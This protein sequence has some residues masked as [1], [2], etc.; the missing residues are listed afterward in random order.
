MP[1]TSV[2][3]CRALCTF[4]ILSELFALILPVDIKI[5]VKAVLEKAQFN[6]YYCLCGASFEIEKDILK[7]L[8]ASHPFVYKVFTFMRNCDIPLQSFN[9]VELISEREAMLGTI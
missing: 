9:L 4:A 7:H 6:E 8:R 1:P 2:Y 5:S 3:K